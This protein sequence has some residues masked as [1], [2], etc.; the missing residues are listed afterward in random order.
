MNKGFEILLLVFSLCIVS[1]G[2]KTN[3]DRYNNSE[4]PR[5]DKGNF[6]E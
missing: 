6:N 3:L 4:Y 2:K 1:C 5:E